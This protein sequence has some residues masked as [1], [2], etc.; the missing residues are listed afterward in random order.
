LGCL[1]MNI[2]AK[3][4]HIIGSV[5]SGKSTLARKLSKDMNIPYFELDNIMWERR[6]TGDRRRSEE[7]RVDLIHS[8][9]TTDYW[10]VEGAHYQSWM[11][12]SLIHADLIIFLDTPKPKRTFRILKR[13]IEEK[14][15]LKKGNYKQTIRMLT[16]MFEWNHR[17]ERDDKENITCLLKPYKHKVEIMKS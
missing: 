2:Q 11:V 16:K 12:D 9:I 13:F 1:K 10:I 6:E 4:I 15:R 8:I 3:K 17:F 5:A 7:E 14:T